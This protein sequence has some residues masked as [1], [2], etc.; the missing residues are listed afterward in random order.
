MNNERALYWRLPRPGRGVAAVWRRNLLVWRRLLVPSLMMNFGEPFLYLIGLGYGVGFYIR[1][2]GELSYLS[3]VASG[4][5]ATVAMMTATY[6]GLYSVYTRMVPQHTYDAMLTTPLAVEDIIAGEILWCA[7]KS[8][9]T[10]CAMLLVALALGAI[11]APGAVLALPVV[12]VVGVCFASLAVVV[13]AKSRSYD[14]FSYYFTLF[15]TP[16]FIFCGVFYP[17]HILPPVAQAVVQYLPLTHAIAVLR[18]LV[19][20]QPPDNVLAHLAVLVGCAL[21]CFYVAVV[22]ARRRLLV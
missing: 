7:T 5:V 2:I 1:E 12:F 20:G 13:T 22:W 21:V 16:M 6:E 10:G 19:T 11:H 9:I 8:V 15:I 3:F 17:V 18:P 4:V 14:F